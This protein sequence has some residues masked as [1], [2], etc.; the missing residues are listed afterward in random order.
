VYDSKARDRVLRKEWEEKCPELWRAEER[1]RELHRIQPA[2]RDN[3]AEK[4][5]GA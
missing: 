2:E 4:V 3:L 5:V 1:L